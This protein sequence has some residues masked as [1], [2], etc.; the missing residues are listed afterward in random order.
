M[1]I[2]NSMDSKIHFCSSWA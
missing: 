2:K 1:E